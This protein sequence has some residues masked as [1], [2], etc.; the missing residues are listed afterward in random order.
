MNNTV[1][2]LKYYIVVLEAETCTLFSEVTGALASS[3]IFLA[4]VFHDVAGV[5]TFTCQKR[6]VK[7]LRRIIKLTLAF[8]VRRMYEFLE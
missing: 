4:A 5:T 3:S 1:K 7:V 8:N 2:A 6:I